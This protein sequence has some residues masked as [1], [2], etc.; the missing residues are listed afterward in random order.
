MNDSK[1]SKIILRKYDNALAE[2]PP[3]C[4][5]LARNCGPRRRRLITS[6]TRAGCR[7]VRLQR[8]RSRGDRSLT[9]AYELA[10]RIE[11]TGKPAVILYLADIKG[12]DMPANIAGKLAWLHQRS[13][14]EERVVIERLA[15]TTEQIERLDLLRKPIEESTAQGT[16]GLAYNRRITEWEQEHGAGATELN[17]LEQHPE[18]F[19]PI[20]REAL[21]QYTDPDLK[22]KNREQGAEWEDD[23][24]K[25]L[26]DLETWL[27]EFNEA[28]AEVADVFARLRAKMSDGSTLGE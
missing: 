5:I 13:D 18:E 23:V 16:D 26:E 22:Q 4:V 15:V 25:L 21:E 14:L 12:Y 6:E 1:R 24:E 3:K 20:V 7:R 2:S 28:Y 9:V 11:A 8:R 27:A 19:R 10:Q 17:A